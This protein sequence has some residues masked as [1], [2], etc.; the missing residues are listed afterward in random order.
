MGTTPD[1]SDF[2]KLVT[3]AVDSAKAVEE[4]TSTEATRAIEALRTLTEQEVTVE[5]LVKTQAGKKIRKLSKH[6]HEGVASAAAAA[7]KGWKKSL[8]GALTEERSEQSERSKAVENR[9]NAGGKRNIEGATL[10]TK[11]GESLPQSE[12]KSDNG[13]IAPKK[14]D[15]AGCKVP[16]TGDTVRDVARKN[17][18]E[19]LRADAEA[20]NVDPVKVAVE[21]E[22][23]AFR[24]NGSVN[25]EYKA[26]MRSLIFNIRDPQNTG[27]R[28]RILSRQISGEVLVTLGSE[29]LASEQ[30]QREIREIKRKKQLECER[31][32]NQQASTD[33]FQCAQCRQRKCTYY[34]LQTRSADEPMTTFVTCVNCGNRWKFC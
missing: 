29:E 24:Q 30:K 4:G 26:K 19:G 12:G 10:E 7:V 16:T 5:L 9:F 27:L 2:L 15:G 6:P 14:A 18:L 11:N 3:T 23:A 17:L 13:I 20:L 22:V 31:G 8:K 25:G 33:A 28:E 34:Q 21:A 1:K 32:G